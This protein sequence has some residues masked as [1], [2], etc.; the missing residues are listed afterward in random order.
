MKVLHCKTHNRDTTATDDVSD[1]VAWEAVTKE[2]LNS[3]EWQEMRAEFREL[4]DRNLNPKVAAM[5]QNSMNGMF[6]ILPMPRRR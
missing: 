1:V 5:M 6:E 3:E 2:E 4:I